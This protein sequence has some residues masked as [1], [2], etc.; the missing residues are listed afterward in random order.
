MSRLSSKSKR[1]QRSRM[2]RRRRRFCAHC[3]TANNLTIDHI[4]PLAKGGANE[5]HNLQMLCEPCNA[6]KADS[7]PYMAADILEKIN[8]TAKGKGD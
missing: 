5:V 4:I 6:E 2:K 1:A 3:G 7:H 8:S